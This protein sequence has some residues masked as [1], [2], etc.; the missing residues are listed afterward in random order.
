MNSCLFN[1]MWIESAKAK[2]A[3]E[4]KKSSS[5]TATESELLEYMGRVTPM[6]CGV[7]FGSTPTPDRIPTCFLGSNYIVGSVGARIQCAALPDSDHQWDE[8]SY[9]RHYGLGSK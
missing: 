1:Q 7:K 3:V 4:K 6:W 9:R 8:Q 5:D 2:W